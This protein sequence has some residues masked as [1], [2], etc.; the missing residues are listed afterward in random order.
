MSRPPMGTLKSILLALA[1]LPEILRLL[2]R[3]GIYVEKRMG[4]DIDTFMK[5]SAQAMDRLEQAQDQATRF[6][7]LREV[8]KL[9]R[10]LIQ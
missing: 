8:Q 6:A 1:A 7:A 10:K 2:E 4:A 5:E 3:F 9:T